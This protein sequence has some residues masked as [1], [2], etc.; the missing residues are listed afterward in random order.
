[1]SVVG[2][3]VI[4]GRSREA[5]E[6]KGIQGRKR[7]FAGTGTGPEQSWIPFPALR[8]AGDDKDTRG[9]SAGVVMTPIAW[10]GAI[11]A[12]TMVLFIWNRVPVTVVAIGS[13]LALWAT[14]IVTLPEAL[15]GFGDTSVVFIASLFV[16][17]SALEATGVTAWVGQ[18][19]VGDPGA[20][21]LPQLLLTLML[22]VGRSDGADQRQWRGGR[23]AAGG[24]RRGRP[25]VGGARRACSC[26][27][28]SPRMP[29]RTSCSQ[30]R[31][32]TCWC[33]TRWSMP[34]CPASATSNS[35]SS[36]CRWWS[37]R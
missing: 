9:R 24:E 25:A 30:E 32:R 16:V 33:R 20:G 2:R 14:G 3:A 6:G 4:P 23:A 11:I 17:S 7:V 5:A 36:A 15:Q 12:G 22:L 29:A 18:K 26:R 27:S 10:T 8:A 1:M 31:R 34:G 28:P 19:L 35:P 13:A 37:A 21:G